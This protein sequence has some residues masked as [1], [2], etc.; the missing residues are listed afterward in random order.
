MQPHRPD[1][2]VRAL[3][4]IV[5]FAFY[6][7]LAGGALLLA[8]SVAAKAFAGADP[9]WTW[10]LPLPAAE[11]HSPTAVMTRWGPA[12]LEVLDE[13]TTLRLPIG[14]LPGWLFAVLWAYV[15][16][17]GALVLLALHHLR[18]IL[19][20]VRDGAPFDASNARR[21]RFLGL[22]LLALSLNGIAERM[23]AMAVSVQVPAL[24]SVRP[25]TLPVDGS[26]VFVALLLVALARIFHRGSDL[27]HDQSLVV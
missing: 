15:A 25:I 1:P 7:V 10:S 23:I 12:Q 4:G 18:R 17:A 11:T 27:E 8:G 21:L 2:I 24:T 14:I 16:A 6:F 22:S 13:R 19:Q 3:T 9:N 20:R 26:L 5:S